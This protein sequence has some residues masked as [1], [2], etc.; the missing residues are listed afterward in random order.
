M[1][2]HVTLR[3][4]ANLPGSLCQTISVW[5]WL[6]R[7]FS[8]NQRALRLCHGDFL[9]RLL[10]ARQP[11]IIGC[12]WRDKGGVVGR[13]FVAAAHT[14]RRTGREVLRN[15]EYCGCKQQWGILKLPMSTITLKLLTCDREQFVCGVIWSACSCT[16]LRG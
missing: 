7:G 10:A 9:R 1:R 14:S 12:R 8:L 3:A 5:A 16:R 6:R 4:T 11:H 15:T 13:N 2:M